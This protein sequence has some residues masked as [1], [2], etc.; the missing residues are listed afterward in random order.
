MFWPLYTLL[1]ILSGYIYEAWFVLRVGFELLS[2]LKY[3]R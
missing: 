3:K 1:Q 2:A